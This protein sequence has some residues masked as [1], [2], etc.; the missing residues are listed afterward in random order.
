MRRR[1]RFSAEILILLLLCFTAFAPFARAAEP[2]AGEVQYAARFA[3]YSDLRTTGLRFGTSSW[4]GA[5]LK[6]DGGELCVS[7][8]SGEKTYLLL[9][10]PDSQ[11]DTYT[12]VYTFRFTDTLSSN[13]YCG[14][15]LSSRGDEPM[16]RTELLIR[17]DGTVDGYTSS[18]NEKLRQAAAEGTPITVR[19]AVKYNF[20]ISFSL[21]TDGEIV[22]AYKPSMLKSISAGG[23]GFVLRNTSAAISSV[24]VVNGTDYTQL[25]GR[26]AEQSYIAPPEWVMPAL[27][28]PPTGD[29]AVLCAA[30]AAA[31]AAGIFFYKKRKS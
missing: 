19:V 9:P 4:T 12:I 29:A 18:P 31:S 30:A 24:T 26:Y 7:S 22:G 3:D 28:A 1:Y 21:E 23:R 8:S 27:P 16:S 2:P 13:A 25:S 14:F 17:A 11:T 5:S 10:T 15:L 6:L 20:L